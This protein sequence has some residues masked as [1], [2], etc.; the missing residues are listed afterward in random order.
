MRAFVGAAGR[1]GISQR[2][3]CV[4]AQLFGIGR[5]LEE[6]DPLRLGGVGVVLG[7]CI[8][9]LYALPR[10][11][12]C[13]VCGHTVPRK[14]DIGDVLERLVA[15]LLFAEIAR[16]DVQHLAVQAFVRVGGVR[17]PVGIFDPAV[18]IIGVHCAGRVGK[19]TGRAPGSGDFV[20]CLRFAA[21][22]VMAVKLILAA[23]PPGKVERDLL[24]EIA[25]GVVSGFQGPFCDFRRERRNIDTL[26]HFVHCARQELAFCQHFV[27]I[28]VRYLDKARLHRNDGVGVVTLKGVQVN[29]IHLVAGVGFAGVA[30]GKRLHGIGRQRVDGW[31]GRRVVA[32]R[33]APIAGVFAAVIIKRA[34]L[35]CRKGDG[36]GLFAVRLA[37]QPP[38]AAQRRGGPCRKE[39]DAVIVALRDRDREQAAAGGFQR[40]LGFKHALAAGEQRIDA[41]QGV[42]LPLQVHKNKLLSGIRRGLACFSRHGLPLRERGGRRGLPRHSGGNRRSGRRRW[43]R[44]RLRRGAGRGGRRSGGRGCRCGGRRGFL[45][46]KRALGHCARGR[47]CCW[48][49]CRFGRLGGRCGG[50]GLLRQGGPGRDRERHA[51]AQ[52]RGKRAFA[53]PQGA[54]VFHLP[55]TFP[56]PFYFI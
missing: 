5:H 33:R 38:D 50:G 16:V 31:L 42:R 6:I 28:A 15:L 39:S 48:F 55:G 18:I 1:D 43:R 19:P 7:V 12:V 37:V 52:Q 30:K 47:G 21:E 11:V 49:G 4:F 17:V 34:Q 36:F 46:A 56:I 23:A 53:P 41:V 24:V 29:K 27:H 2:E 25:A 44:R 51:K 14:E 45:Y 26:A 10:L 22:A 20:L 54:G 9:Q 13:H 35:P 8:I 3:N 40:E 32:G